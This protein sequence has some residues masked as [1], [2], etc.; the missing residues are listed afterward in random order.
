MRDDVFD[1]VSITSNGEIETPIAV[2]A[3]LPEI[4]C[5]I[6]LLCVERRILEIGFEES[7]LLVER[8]LDDGR[9]I[10][11]CLDGTFGEKDLH[12]P[13]RLG[14]TVLRVRISFRRNLTASS[15]VSNGPK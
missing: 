3:G 14:L 2:D 1:A 6:V 10:F 7:E 5:L 15:A 8:T 12:E 13:E 4:R 11:Q 9:R